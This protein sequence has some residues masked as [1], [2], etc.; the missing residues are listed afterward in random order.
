MSKKSDALKRK[1]Q[2]NL[3]KAKVQ[4]AKFQARARVE[5]A[6]H[7]RAFKLAAKRYKLALKQS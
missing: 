4:L 1:A 3:K 6:R 5:L 7:G 2:K